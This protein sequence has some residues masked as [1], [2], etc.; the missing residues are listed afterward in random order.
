ME[1]A[2]EMVEVCSERR[3]SESSMKSG[4]SRGLRTRCRSAGHASHL[5]G[6]KTGRSSV[7]DDEELVGCSKS[8]SAAVPHRR[9]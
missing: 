5:K 7:R 9:L 2:D 1:M 4:E 8:G 3:F 6:Y